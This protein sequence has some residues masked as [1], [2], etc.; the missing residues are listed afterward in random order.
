MVR[1]LY[2]DKLIQ[3]EY[4]RITDFSNDALQRLADKYDITLDELLDI[5]NL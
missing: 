5:I 4:N 3:S 1:D 2:T